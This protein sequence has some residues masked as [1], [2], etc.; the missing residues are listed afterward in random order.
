MTNSAKNLQDISLSV[1]DL[2]PVMVG[3]TVADAL[4]RSLDLAQHVEQW[5]FKR[6][7]LAEHH[8]MAGIAS[9][10]TAVVIGYIAGGTSTIRVG[11][12]GIM[13]PNHA[14]LV[15]AEQF[16]TLAAL[17]PNRID[18]GIGRAPGTDPLTVRALH[19][20]PRAHARDFPDLLEELRGYFSSQASTRAV[21]SIPAEGMNVPIWLLGSS[22]YS[23]QLAGYLGL[24]FAHAGQFAAENTQM[25][26]DAYRSSFR[27]SAVLQEPYVMLGVSVV[28]ADTT[29]KARYLSTTQQQKLLQLIRG[30]LKTAQMAPPVANMEPLWDDQEKAMV[31][32]RLRASIIGDAPTVR[33][34]LQSLLDATQADELIITSEIY[35]HA[36]RLRSYEIVGSVW[37]S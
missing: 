27:P 8:N 18:L 14:P 2:S 19:R 30:R 1:L 34:G 23:A 37:K 36:D 33:A 16:G 9:S 35:H 29:E 5:D 10:A 12:G 6:Y 4:H 15:I 21:R 7:W 17:Y 11:S 22:D 20:D 3:G 32:G 24:P 31:E 28:A 13:L 26:L 25:A